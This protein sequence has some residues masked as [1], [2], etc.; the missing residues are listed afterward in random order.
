MDK[1]VLFGLV[2]NL[3]NRRDFSLLP[4][5]SVPVNTS[6]T[7]ETYRGLFGVAAM[8]F[9]TDLGSVSRGDLE[10]R[11]GKDVATVSCRVFLRS[12]PNLRQ[13]VLGS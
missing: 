12:S 13:V 3:I 6:S 11:G 10:A 7:E 4:S 1:G 8:A 9:H 2:P 5:G